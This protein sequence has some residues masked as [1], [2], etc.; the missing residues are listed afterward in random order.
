MPKG[1]SGRGEGGKYDG[2]PGGGGKATAVELAGREVMTSVAKALERGTKEFPEIQP[3]G[4]IIEIQE[5][6]FKGTTLGEYGGGYVTIQRGLKSGNHQNSREWVAAHE[7]A[8]GLTTNTPKGYRT[9]EQTMRS[10][11]RAYNKGRTSGRLTEAGLA[12][13]ITKYARSSPRE[14]VAEAFAQ[15][16][17]QGNKSS[18][19]AQII[20]SKWKKR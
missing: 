15:W 18:E 4:R 2:E 17:I 1:S 13:Q 9:A 19:A 12:G 10:A 6:N 20:M 3:E 8:H 7:V 14:A 5:A 11:V 16:S